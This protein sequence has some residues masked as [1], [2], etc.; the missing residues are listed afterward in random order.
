MTAT[1]PGREPLSHRVVRDLRDAILHA[2]LRP[3]T[4]LTEVKLARDLSVSRTPVREALAQLAREGFLTAAPGRGYAVAPLSS[5]EVR[6]LYAVIAELECLALTW[7]GR[8]GMDQLTALQDGNARLA[9]VSDE[10]EQAMALNGEWHRTLVRHCPNLQL[11]RLVEE[12]RWR[13]YRYEYYYFAAGSAHVRVAVGLH[14]AI[15]EPLAAGDLSAA[16]AAVRTHWLTDLDHMLP[17]ILDAAE[18]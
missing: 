16:C 1:V 9:R 11:R 8:V 10:T 12:N 13:A 6:E 15:T 7:G 2:R 14:R 5:R 4:R 17:A 18:T 3:G